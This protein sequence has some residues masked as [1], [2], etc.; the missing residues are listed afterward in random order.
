MPSPLF[1]VPP[2]GATTIGGAFAG[3]IGTAQGV[4]NVPSRAATAL[5][6]AVRGVTQPR[7]LSEQAEAAAA[8]LDVYYTNVLDSRGTQTLPLQGPYL[9][10]LND[11]VIVAFDRVTEHAVS[12]SDQVSEFP[13]DT[14]VTATDHITLGPQQLTLQAAITA[15]PLSNRPQGAGSS[16]SSNLTP[17]AQGKVSRRRVTAIMKALDDCRGQVVEVA[18]LKFFPR[19]RNM[20]I[21]NITSTV[22]NPDEVR[23]TI[24]MRE[25]FRA[26]RVE[27]VVPKI[28]QRPPADKGTQRAAEVSENDTSRIREDATKTLLAAAID[29]LLEGRIP[30]AAQTV[31]LTYD[32]AGLLGS[33][34]T[35]TGAGAP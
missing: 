19:I 3:S 16:R 29:G 13:V 24:Q 17:E 20:V 5:G 34:F 30:G 4:Y 10:A 35:I 27:T 14:G 32:S 9:V 6:Q 8:A 26:T 12:V 31:N 28:V 21:T 11:T 23:I 7:K 25:I 15:S 18:D 33:G 2:L 22:S 1:G